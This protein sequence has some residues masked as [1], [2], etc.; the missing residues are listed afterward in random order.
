MG[1]GIGWLYLADEVIEANENEENLELE[2]VSTYLKDA[3]SSFT[4]ALELAEASK[5]SP[6]ALLLLLGEAHV[7]M[8]NITD[9]D[10]EEADNQESMGHYRMA[11]ENFRRVQVTD[12]EALPEQF[13]EFLL[14]WEAELE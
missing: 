5:K 1:L 2:P 4:S 3:I 7:H 9:V 6:I 10:D 8:G 13:E 11:V 12:K 14:E